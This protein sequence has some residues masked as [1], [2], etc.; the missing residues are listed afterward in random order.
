[1]T[2]TVTLTDA[3]TI[4]TIYGPDWA[5]LGTIRRPYQT[6]EFRQAIEHGDKWT[7]HDNDGK[8][9]LARHFRPSFATIAALFA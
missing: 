5:I 8:L 1:M 9:L 6:R 4:A 2:I 7:V 3:D